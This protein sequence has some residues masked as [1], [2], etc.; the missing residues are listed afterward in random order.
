MSPALAVDPYVE[1]TR[2]PFDGTLELNRSGA[3]WAVPSL[4]QSGRFVLRRQWQT[5][6]SAD[7]SRVGGRFRLSGGGDN[8]H[9]V[10]LDQV[11]QGEA[12]FPG[13]LD[14][15]FDNGRLEVNRAMAGV[16]PQVDAVLQEAARQLLLMAGHLP[17]GPIE[18]GEV[19][20]LAGEAFEVAALSTG[21]ALLVASRHVGAVGDEPVYPRQSGELSEFQLQLD[22]AGRLASV[23][24]V[25][26]SYDQ[27]TRDFRISRLWIT[28]ETR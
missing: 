22:A 27:A 24:R 5:R 7:A 21:Q 14:A 25:I 15:E 17:H 8:G 23:N 19:L 11:V 9:R 18:D 6:T 3:A 28:P 4:F 20:C 1:L 10:R 2:R 12:A 26:A 13:Y 16:P